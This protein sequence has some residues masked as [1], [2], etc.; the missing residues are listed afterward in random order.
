MTWTPEVK[1]ALIK[2]LVE[3]PVGPCHRCG[4][5]DFDMV[6]GFFV[7]MVSEATDVMPFSHLAVTA[8]PTIVTVCQKCGALSQHAIGALGVDLEEKK[9]VEVAQ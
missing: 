3:K 6:N 8:I 1:N 4:F 5:G 7:H 9:L 2:A